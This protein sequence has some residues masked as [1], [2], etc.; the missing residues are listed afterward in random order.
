MQTQLQTLDKKDAQM[1]RTILTI[2][3]CSAFMV[4][5]TGCRGSY[6]SMKGGQTETSVTLTG[7][8]YRLIKG[9]AVGK[10]SGFR[11]LCIIPFAAP[12]Y[13]NA[14]ASLYKSV[15][16]PLTGRA[17]ALANQTEDR[18]L[19]VFILFSVPKITITADVIEFVDPS[20]GGNAAPPTSTTAPATTTTTTNAAPK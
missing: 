8:N 15:G 4:L 6:G 12:N 3:L 7:K 17:I 18:S 9:G 2:A 20:V 14:K 16:E 11:F 10:S 5:L 19:T 13:A 1:K